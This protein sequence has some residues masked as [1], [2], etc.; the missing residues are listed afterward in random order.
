MSDVKRVETIYYPDSRSYEEHLIPV[1]ATKGSR[2]SLGTENARLKSKIGRLCIQNN[3]LRKEMDKYSSDLKAAE[4]KLI[5]KDKII[6][7]YRTL[8]V[9][10]L[11]A[12]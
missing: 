5:E 7:G 2:K 4:Q 12:P 9:D 6:Q 10:I 11:K 3:E 1:S 8:A